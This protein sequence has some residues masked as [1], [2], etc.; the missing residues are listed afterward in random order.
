MLRVLTN[1]SFARGLKELAQ[2]DPTL[3]RILG[4]LG[5]PPLW[6][7]R[8]GFVTLLRVILEQQVSLASAWAIYQRLRRADGLTPGRLL[9]LGDAGLRGLGV[10]RQM[11]ASLLALARAVTEGPLALAGLAGL[12]DDAARAALTTVKGVGPWTADVYLLLGHRRPDVWPAGD[13][14]LALAVQRAYRLDAPPA[15]A[16]LDER[17]AAWRPWRA[18]AARVLW[19]SYLAARGGKGLAAG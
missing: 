6:A 13:R 5:P 18:V 10:T 11:A 4:E 3:A 14:A 1:R 15:P 8:P 2:R 17:G 16:N 7:R 9:A 19:H 12:D